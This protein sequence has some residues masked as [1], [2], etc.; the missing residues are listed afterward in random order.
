[1]T[2]AATFRW[3]VADAEVGLKWAKFANEHWLRSG[4][5]RARGFRVLVGPNVGQWVFAIEFPDL[6]TYDKARLAFRALPEYA[7]MQQALGK[8][9]S[10]LLDVGLIEEFPL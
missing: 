9:G 8:T 5:T 4:A 10:T 3:K 6:A 1:M 7:Q 2:I